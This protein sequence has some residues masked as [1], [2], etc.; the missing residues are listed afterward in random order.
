MNTIKMRGIQVL[1]AVI[2]VLV[3]PELFGVNRR[4]GSGTVH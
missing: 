1:Q 2:Q 3:V 4:R